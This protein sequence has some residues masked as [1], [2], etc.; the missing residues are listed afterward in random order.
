VIGK[1]ERQTNAGM[2]RFSSTG[3]AAQC[4]LQWQRLGDVLEQDFV[5][6]EIQC[7]F[8]DPKTASV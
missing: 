5:H 2:A 8:V 4:C 7:G 3:H 6:G 1:P